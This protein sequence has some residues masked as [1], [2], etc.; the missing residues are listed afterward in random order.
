ML[1]PASTLTATLAPN[2]TGFCPK[3]HITQLELQL[4]VRAHHLSPLHLEHPPLEAQFVSPCPGLEGGMAEP[5]GLRR[6]RRGGS[7]SYGR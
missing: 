2:S 1:P 4:E 3:F 7:C 5:G 6:A